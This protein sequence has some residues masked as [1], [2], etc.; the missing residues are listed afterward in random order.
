MSEDIFNEDLVVNPNDV[1]T[2]K[3][4]DDRYMLLDG[5]YSNI[6][7]KYYKLEK[8]GLSKDE[9]NKILWSK[10]EFNLSK[11]A[12]NI[13]SNMFFPKEELKNIID[14]KILNVVEKV[15]DIAKQYIENIQENFYYCV[16]MHLNSTYE[17]LKQGRIV[18]NLESDYIKKEY[19]NEYRIAKI[20]TKEIN[21]SLDIELP[22]DEIGFIAMYLKTFSEVDKNVSRV[23]VIVLSHGHVACGMV[24]VA[25]KLL[26]T[27]LAVGIEMSLDE[28][29][30]TLL[31]R[32]IEVV[33]RVNEGKGC[34]IL[35]D[36]G[37]LVTFGEIIT[38][39]TGI[40]TRVIG[41]VDTVMVL[42]A[43][44]RSL[45]EN[46]NL[47]EISKAL[48]G[49]KAYVGKVK[50]ANKYTKTIITIC[51][52]GEG[53]ALKIKKY[54]EDVVLGNT[55]KNLRIISVGI[56]NKD[57]AQNEIIKISRDHDI[58]A[59][60]GTIDPEL[61]SIPFISFQDI[62]KESGKLRLK[63]FLGINKKQFNPL[64]NVIDEELIKV[65]ND[66]FTK[67][68]LI[69]EMCSLLISKGRVSE[70]FT[71]SVY[72]RE[73]LGGT[74]FEG[75]FGIPHGLSEFVEKS[76]I[77]IFKLNNPILWDYNCMVDVV[78]MLALKENDGKVVRQ[79][80]DTLSRTEVANKLRKSNSPK[81]ISDILLKI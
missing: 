31:E 44:R 8:Q 70:N 57:N 36:M 63:E 64:I 15:T 27:N 19:Y 47:Y 26:G 22:E 9:I 56:I 23:A 11:F 53:T 20:L 38:K 39:E 28:N 35:V 5:I 51:I 7:E 50:G 18:R 10:V 52:T 80:F 3:S 6:E 45:M 14:E 13:E 49:D 40:P 4:K 21:N 16:A 46:S 54:L 72:K 62:L 24:D 48:D 42:E 76:S 75:T 67:S 74:L 34:L 30:Q 37:S 32:A 61:E 58:A 1:V 65:N 25:N 71:M 81:E 12:K 77:A 55:N 33:K 66:S 69:D 59:I 43:V 68:D 17:R 78:I 29:P 73:M 60:V 79:L 2:Q 41:R